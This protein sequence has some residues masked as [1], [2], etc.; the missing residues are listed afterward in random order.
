[1][2]WIYNGVEYGTEDESVNDMATAM[3]DNDDL[4]DIKERLLEA[5]GAVTVYKEMSW[6]SDIFEDSLRDTTIDTFIDEE[7]PTDGGEDVRGAEWKEPVKRLVFNMSIDSANEGVQDAEG[8]EYCL[9]RVLTAIKD[10]GTEGGTV[11]D[12]NGNSVGEWTAEWRDAE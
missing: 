2:P 5:L 11:F 1:M 8:L 12:V 4:D 6:N 7:V 9:N 3:Y 10:Y